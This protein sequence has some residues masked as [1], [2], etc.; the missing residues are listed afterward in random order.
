MMDATYRLELREQNELDFARFDAM[1]DQRLAEF[2][3]EIRLGFAT[4]N[5]KLDERIAQFETRFTRHMVELWIAQAAMTVGLVFAV[6]KL[7]R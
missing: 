3:T 1:L 6:M 2:R 5:A 7:L 4:F